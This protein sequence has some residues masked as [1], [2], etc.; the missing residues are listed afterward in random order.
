[1]KLVEDREM[2]DGFLTWVQRQRRLQPT[3][4]GTYTDHLCSGLKFI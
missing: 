1:M 2:V 4:M 3:T